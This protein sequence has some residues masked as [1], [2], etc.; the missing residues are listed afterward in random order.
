MICLSNR[1]RYYALPH[2]III[3]IIIN[4]FHCDA[5]SPLETA[6]P[7]LVEFMLSRCARTVLSSEL[8]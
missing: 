3:I 2:N 4:E 8:A 7:V 6:G 1:G 5:I